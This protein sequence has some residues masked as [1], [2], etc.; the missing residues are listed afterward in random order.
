MIT[1]HK[2]TEFLVLV[3]VAVWSYGTY[4]FAVLFCALCPDLVQ[5][6]SQHWSISAKQLPLFLCLLPQLG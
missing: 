1:L 4:L 6:P 3:N 5:L 2:V